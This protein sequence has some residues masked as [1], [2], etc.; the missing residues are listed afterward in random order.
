MDGVYLERILMN[1]ELNQVLYKKGSLL[2]C[3]FLEGEMILEEVILSNREMMIV[4]RRES[5]SQRLMRQYEHL[6]Y[7]S[8]NTIRE[9]NFMEFLERSH[10]PYENALVI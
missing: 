8:R 4:R 9:E 7:V 2:L 5:S 1:Q 3:Y 10:T 6:F